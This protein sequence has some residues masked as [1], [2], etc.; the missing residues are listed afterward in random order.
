MAEQVQVPEKWMDGDKAIGLPS[1][2]MVWNRRDGSWWTRPVGVEGP[3]IRVPVSDAAVK[4]LVESGEIE[5]MSLVDRPEPEGIPDS[6]R[7][8]ELCDLGNVGIG[9]WANRDTPRSQKRLGQL[10]ALLMAGAEY[11]VGY[12]P[13]ISQ[14][15][16]E[17]HDT[18]WVEVTFPGFDAFEHVPDNRDYWETDTFYVPTAERLER[19]AGKDWY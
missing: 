2:A 16:P 7:L 10:R 4:M 19:A 13:E 3:L 6:T 11:R 1:R 17:Q 8:I 18:W 5:I 12:D 9:G 14:E 15:K